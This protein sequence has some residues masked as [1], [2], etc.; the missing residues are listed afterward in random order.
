MSVE[1]RVVGIIIEFNEISDID[2]LVSN[3]SD[4]YADFGYDSLDG[5]ELLMDI[6]DEF[7][8]SIPDEDVENIRTVGQLI[9]YIEGRENDKSN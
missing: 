5:V 6:E 8:I 1:T 2:G 4:F 7:D 9:E 3:E